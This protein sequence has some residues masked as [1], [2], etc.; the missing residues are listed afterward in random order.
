[1]GATA[2]L[3]A[4]VMGYEG[5]HELRNVNYRNIDIGPC[6][7][8][9]TPE[10]QLQLR[11]HDYLMGIFLS[12]FHIFIFKPKSIDL[13]LNLDPLSV[14]M[15]ESCPDRI[16]LKH[17]FLPSTSRVTVSGKLSSLLLTSLK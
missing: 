12:A 3:P 13:S 8:L 7:V 16:F 15:E 6:T 2:V 10:I 11:L 17:Q 14:S 9:K 5:D 4:S 1:M